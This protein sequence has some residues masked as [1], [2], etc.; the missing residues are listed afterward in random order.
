MNTQILFFINILKIFI[1]ETRGFSLKRFLYRIAGVKIGLNVR[2]CSSVNIIGNGFLS[3]GD[4]SWIGH[5]CLIISSSEII[6]GNNV[7]IGPRVYIGTGSHIIDPVGNHVAGKG[8]NRNIIIEDG[9]WIGV[10]CTILPDVTI[11]KNVVVA[12][13]SL[14]SR[15]VSPYTIVAGI[16]AIPIKTWDREKNVWIS[17]INK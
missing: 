14:V 4:N 15:S 8:F 11:E 2:I 13:G 12:A 6:I 3:I 17:F 7:D 9:C 16:P 1:P 5:Q 10:D